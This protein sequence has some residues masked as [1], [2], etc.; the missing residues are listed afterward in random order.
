MRKIN[1]KNTCQGRRHT[2]ESQ[3]KPRYD[4]THH[5]EV[6]NPSGLPDA[7]GLINLLGC[8]LQMILSAT[9]QLM[10]DAR[11]MLSGHWL[12]APVLCCPLL[13]V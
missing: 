1:V 5:N 7:P 3:C 11:S 10:P 4:Q 2:S 13:C 9:K 12:L 8:R 6:T